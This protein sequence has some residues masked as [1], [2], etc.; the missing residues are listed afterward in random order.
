M[1]LNPITN[2]VY[3]YDLK[4]FGEEPVAEEHI[5]LNCEARK[6]TVREITL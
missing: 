3:E 2:D 4:G 1:L 6:L 5:I